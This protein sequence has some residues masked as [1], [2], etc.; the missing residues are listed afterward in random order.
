MRG[1]VDYIIAAA[2]TVLLL[3]GL[4]MVFSASSMVANN[5]FGS[6]TYFFRKQVLWGAIAFIMMLIFSRVNYQRLKDHHKPGIFILIS[7]VLLAGLFLFGVRIN[8]ATRWY[9][10]WLFNFQPSEPA[11]IALII[12]F[13]YMLSNPKK[14]L[15]SFKEGLLPLTLVMVSVL[16]MIMLQPDLST[17]LMIGVICLSLLFVSRVKF[18]HIAALGLPLIPA[19]IYLTVNG[20]Q[21]Q[22]IINWIEGWQNP[23]AANYQVR[24]S[25][26]GLGRGGYFGQ[27]L[28]QGKQKFLF[29]PDSHT[30]FIFSIIGEEFGYIGTTL[31]L[32]LFLVILFRGLYVVRRTPDN[33]GKFLALGFTLNIVFYAMINAAVVSHLLPATG[34]PMPLISYGGSN[35]LF[36]GISIGMLLS[37]SRRSSP[38]DMS[39]NWNEIRQKREQLFSRVITID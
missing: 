24:Q 8:G 6:L 18:V 34:L 11:R 36:L 5:N 31:I 26:I 21:S 22:R 16:L 19:I 37:I 29:L 20:Y 7:I 33:F 12:Y 38:M 23:L 28:G 39:A 25:L 27:G 32:L 9:H 17:A 14:N 15:S 13:A 2:V 10:L 30:D 4:I 3:I 1:K 35:L